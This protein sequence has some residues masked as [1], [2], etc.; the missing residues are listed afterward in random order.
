MDFTESLQ[1]YLCPHLTPDPSIDTLNVVFGSLATCALLFGVWTNFKLNNLI[2]QHAK[3]EM[4]MNLDSL[5]DLVYEDLVQQTEESPLRD[6]D[7][8]SGILD[9]DELEDVPI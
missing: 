7:Q 9:M 1:E 8:E 4:S 6:S 5:V 3:H 2:V